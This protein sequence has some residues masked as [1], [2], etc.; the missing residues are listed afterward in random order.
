MVGR[1]RPRRF[2]VRLEVED[3][4]VTIQVSGVLDADADRV[5]RDELLGV[6]RL[7]QAIRLDL[8]AVSEICAGLRLQTFLGQLRSDCELSR[9]RFQVLAS[10]PLV[11]QTLESWPNRLQHLNG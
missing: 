10:H 9:C 8:R 7:A 3:G 4:L 2:Q 1:R 5:I 6:C 11:L